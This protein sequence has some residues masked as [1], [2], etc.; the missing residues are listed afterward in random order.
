MTM[1]RKYYFILETLLGL[2]TLVIIN[3]TFFPER[4]A[5]IGVSPHP[6]W[7]IILLV[8]S[9]YGTF[10]GFVA[11]V[12]AAG[13]YGYLGASAGLLNFS[14]VTFPHGG[15]WLPLLFMFVG[16]VLG[17]IRSVYKKM[18]ENLQRRYQETAEKLRNFKTHHQS[19]IE[20]K[21]ALHRRFTQQSAAL[22][23]LF[24]RVSELEELPPQTLYSNIPQIVVDLLNAERASVYLIEENL[25]RLHTRVGGD[26]KLPDTLELTE[27]MIAEVVRT[28]NVLTISRSVS[29]RQRFKQLGLIMSAPIHLNDDSVIGVINIEK[30][31]F[32][33]FNT[34]AVKTFAMLSNWL[35]VAAEKSLRFHRFKDKNIDDA[36]TGA[37]RFP[38][39][40]KRLSYEI[41][42]ARRF[43][44]PLSLLLIEIA[45]FDL[46]NTA[47]QREALS[48][49]SETFNSILDEIDII[50][51]YK[52]DGVF[53]IILPGQTSSDAEAVI[54]RLTAA[55]QHNPLR[56]FA[57]E[58][59]LLSLS[60]TDPLRG[61]VGLSSLQ[62][63][64]GTFESL[65]A[66]AEERLQKNRRQNFSGRFEDLRFLLRNVRNQTQTV[67]A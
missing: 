52:T 8:A 10:E 63:T 37:Y 43:K 64:E 21:R 29:D 53:A 12:A 61:N 62:I 36:V 27:G 2:T 48:R 39:F 9:R 59:E 24:D 13:L 17:E 46:M 41:T 32:H 35:S 47:E 28:K 56:P 6:Y 20:S 19:L 30:I 49:L 54:Q 26:G 22:F 55:I 31:P 14:L 57:K 58:D 4:P 7:I 3:Q 50:S 18:F 60:D 1:L 33:D 45:E 25:L 44:S 67:Q 40:Q 23:R 66:R 51:Q 34:H 65:L 5:F 15:H 11:G 42:R 38:Y 16:Y